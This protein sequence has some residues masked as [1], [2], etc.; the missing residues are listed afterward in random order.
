MVMEYAGEELFQYI[1]DLGKRGVRTHFVTRSVHSLM[2]QIGERD[3]RRIFQQMMAALEYCHKHNIAHRDLKPEKWVF[4]PPTT[5]ITNMI[6][7]CSIPERLASRISKSPTSVYV[8][9]CRTVISSR[10]LVV[11][12]TMLLP[13][14]LVESKSLCLSYAD[15]RLYSGPEIDVWSA[16][17]ILFVL[18]AGKLPFDSEQVPVLFKMIESQSG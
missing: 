7:C 9:S 16:G 2:S 4:L 1:V 10:H 8:T 6:A 11:V 13:K 18:V 15:S 5:L 3:A 14:L 12:Q 17:V